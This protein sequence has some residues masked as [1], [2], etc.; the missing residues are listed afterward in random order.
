MHSKLKKKQSR[1]GQK[2]NQPSAS[3]GEEAMDTK[4]QLYYTTLYKW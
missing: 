3:S 2:Y 1:E 4:S